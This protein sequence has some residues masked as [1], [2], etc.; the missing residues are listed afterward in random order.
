[1][2][3]SDFP[4]AET[5]AWARLWS[6]TAFKVS[7][8]CGSGFRAGGQLGWERC[9]LS[10]QRPPLVLHLRLAHNTAVCAF[11]VGNIFDQNSHPLDSSDELKINWGGGQPWKVFSVLIHRITGVRATS[12]PSHVTTCKVGVIYRECLRVRASW[13]LHLIFLQTANIANTTWHRV[14]KR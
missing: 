1:M 8:G 10:S 12:Y 6:L 4:Q 9:A 5:K 3:S 14:D 2:A 11:T 7:Y 13:R